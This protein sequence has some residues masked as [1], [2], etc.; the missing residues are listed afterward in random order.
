MEPENLRHAFYIR[1]TAQ[2][3]R[4][5]LIDV[6]RL[7]A[8]WHFRYWRLDPIEKH[9]IAVLEN[10]SGSSASAVSQVC[11]PRFN[12]AGQRRLSRQIRVSRRTISPPVAPSPHSRAIS[13]AGIPVLTAKGWMSPARAALESPLTV[14]RVFHLNRRL[15]KM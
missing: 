12:P 5:A 2:H 8:R 7:L 9:R 3:C 14:A 13:R 6:A 10:G 15:S 11:S 1:W 4:R